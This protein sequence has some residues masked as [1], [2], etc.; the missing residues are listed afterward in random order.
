M[1][2]FEISF[3][4]THPGVLDRQNELVDDY[5][6]IMLS[7][8]VSSGQV[9]SYFPHGF[10]FSDNNIRVRVTTPDK[11]SLSPDYDNI[12]VQQ[13][14]ETLREE[15]GIEVFQN[16]IGFIGGVCLDVNERVPGN[17][18]LYGG[19]SQP[20]QTLEKEVDIPL[21]K[22]PYINGYSFEDIIT[23]K[24]DYLACYRVWMRSQVGEQ[25]FENQLVDITSDLSKNGIKLSK[26]VS[27]LAN[28]K[29]YYYL[30]IGDLEKDILC[31]P[32]CNESWK[33]EA[34]IREFL[35]KCDKC[36]IVS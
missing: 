25:F 3:K 30:M 23:W 18:V 29:C 17:L 8:Y 13:W 16:H 33:L 28:L 19:A 10:E 4:A 26:L 5:I 7:N 27:Q 21:Y 36:L 35:Y 9:V 24:E 15:L 22:I 2:Y 1:E 31:C 12:Y 32:S 34:P 11:D 6:E 14:K 20:L